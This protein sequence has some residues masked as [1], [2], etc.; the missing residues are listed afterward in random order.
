MELQNFILPSLVLLSTLTF[1]HIAKK[2]LMTKNKKL[3]PG[4]YGF[5]IIGSL[6]TIGDRPHE[7]LANLSKTYG[8]LMTV[9]FGLIN[10]VVASSTEMAKEILQKN[11]QAFL[12]RPIPDAVTAEKGYEL[13]MAW[14]PGGPQWNKLRKICKSQIFSAQ[15]LDL[16]Q[17]LRHHMMDKMIEQVDKA[18]A[19]GEAVHIGRLVFGTTL[20]LLSN[21]MFSNDMM[22]PKS[23]EMRELKVLIGK[24]M[25]LAGRPN[26][27]DFFPFVKAFDLQGIRRE[28]KVSYDRLHELVDESIGRRMKRRRSN[29][30]DRCGDFLDVLLDST[31]Q[32]KR[33][34]EALTH[35]DV[36]LLLMDL[37]IGGTDTTTTT[38]EWVM[39]ELL[40]NPT[41]LTKVKQELSQKITQGKS[42]QEQDIPQ[43]PYLE[44]IIKETMRMHPTAPLLLPHRAEEEVEIRGYTIPKHTQIFVNAWSILRDNAYWNEPTIFKPERFLDSEIE[45]SG[46]DF[47]FTPFGTGRR[48]CP[49]LNLGV[50]MVS[51]ILANL[52]HNFDWKLPNGMMS[53]DLDMNDKFGV[54]LQKAEP[55]VAVPLRIERC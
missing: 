15:R 47:S 26:V 45:F 13:S 54:T 53:Q 37:F 10:I 24:I 1:L 44:A 28:I 39:T 14:L 31:D 4:P 2:I 36:I 5:P 46:R 34:S 48:I 55:L 51:L 32:E 21:T 43:L 52:V 33:G 20:N 12:G 29:G 11:D 27:S 9:K 42:I 38:L 6:V 40:H 19:A 8:P 49:G 23:D 7:S 16:L 50:R 35:L 22:D 25:E 41:I 17:D 30:S 3:P 18:C